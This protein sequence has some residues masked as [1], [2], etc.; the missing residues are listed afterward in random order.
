MLLTPRYDNIQRQFPEK[1]NFKA[2]GFIKAALRVS[3]SVF[4]PRRNNV[5]F[6]GCYLCAVMVNSRVCPELWQWA[7]MGLFV[8]T[9]PALTAAQT[10]HGPLGRGR[11]VRATPP[12]IGN[13]DEDLIS[14]YWAS[15]VSAGA[16]DGIV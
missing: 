13:C 10:T 11:P 2:T 9:G 7:P 16:V 8:Q 6:S 3:H 4:S 1:V 5:F 14:Y 12:G 15:P